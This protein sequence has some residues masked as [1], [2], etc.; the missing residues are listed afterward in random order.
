M[1]KDPHLSDYYKI[2]DFEI[3]PSYTKWRK[4]E[5][6]RYY[7]EKVEKGQE[8]WKQYGA[9]ASRWSLY[10][11]EEGPCHWFWDAFS[12]RYNLEDIEPEQNATIWLFPPESKIPIHRD[13]DSLGWIGI[14][15]IGDQPLEFFDGDK[16][17][18]CEVQYDAICVDSQQPHRA[19]VL[20]KERVLLRK[21]FLETPY[22]EVVKRFE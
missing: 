1:N 21:A 22:S 13:P 17:K 10:D 7:R 4:D 20:G 8:L 18:L 5:M 16:N 2:I 12:K 14:K 9:G 11:L 15:L 6:V 3:N 19:D